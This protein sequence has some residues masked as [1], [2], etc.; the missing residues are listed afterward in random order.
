MPRHVK[1]K[2]P[3]AVLGSLDDSSKRGSK[4]RSDFILAVEKYLAKAQWTN[5]QLMSSAKIGE[6]QYY[7]WASNQSVPR[8]STV[9]RLAVKLAVR[10]DEIK[11]DRI[12]D[13]CPASDQMDGML[14]E[15]LDAAGYAASVKGEASNY[16]W[17]SIADKRSWTLGYTKIPKWSELALDSR[18]GARPTGLAIDY[19]ERIGRLLGIETAWE[20]LDYEEMPLAIRER[21]VDGIA[22]SM[23]V[24]PGRLFDYRFSE[25]CGED[26]FRLA[27]LVAPEQAGDAECLE[28]LPAKNVQLLHIK[29]ELGEWG[30]DVL[31]KPY[32]KQLFEE[33]TGALSYLKAN[34]K[35]KN[36]VPAFLID[37][38]TGHFLANDYQLKLLNIKTIDL[39]TYPAFAFHPDEDQLIVAVNAAINLT[40]NMTRSL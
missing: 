27:A 26:I 35:A 5:Q 16:A 34:A 30:A 10:I 3:D 4:P 12:H 37:S 29:G 21:K 8:K 17:H 23:L 7:R 25:K 38:V 24:L 11:G 20:Y 14:N 9:N 28:D 40:P 1:E 36:L 19:A 33:E 32:Q 13:P 18:R 39:E 6:S 22:P 15:L 31:G 2:S